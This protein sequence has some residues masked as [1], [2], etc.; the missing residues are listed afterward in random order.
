[1]KYK[2]LTAVTALMMA[3]SVT[4]HA[5]NLNQ[6]KQKTTVGEDIRSGLRKTDKAMHEAGQ[7]IKAFFVGTDDNVKMS[8]VTIRGALTARHLIGKAI[9]NANNDKIATVEDIIIAKDGHAALIVV[10]DG[11]VLGIGEKLAAFD[12][13]RV[14]TQKA[15]GGVNLALSQEMV[16]NA[17]DFSYEAKDAATAKVIPAGSISA[18]RLLKG[19]VLDSNGKKVASIEDLYF[20]NGDVVQIIVGFNKTLGLS[21][22]RAAIDYDDLRTIRDGDDVHFKLTPGQSTQFKSFKAALDK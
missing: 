18:K 10:S 7:D 20:R 8:P 1:M 14:L 19:D 4:V 9:V 12:Y 11:G 13:S 15:D 16:D 3:A 21:G 17:A 5:E 22:D 2:T 6:N